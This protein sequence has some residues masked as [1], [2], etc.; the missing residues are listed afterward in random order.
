MTPVEFY[1]RLYNKLKN[2]TPLKKDCGVLCDKAC[3]DED[4]ED[5]AGMLLFP[6]EEFMLNNASFGQIEDY[7]FEYAG[8]KGK[9]FLCNEPCDRRVRPLACRIFPLAPYLKDGKLTLIMNPMAKKMCPLARSLKTTQLEND[10]VRAVLE[11]INNIMKLKE[12]KE[13]IKAYTEMLDDFIDLQK[14]FIK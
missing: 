6:Y 9:L 14:T 5:R 7:P 4:M 11:T 3:C 2:I 13:Y 12:G 1:I 10:F 8:K